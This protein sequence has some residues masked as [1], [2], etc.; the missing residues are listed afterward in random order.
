MLTELHME[1]KRKKFKKKIYLDPFVL[2][3]DKH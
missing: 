3:E 1:I 2:P